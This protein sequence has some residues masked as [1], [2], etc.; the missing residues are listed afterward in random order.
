MKG[1]EAVAWALKNSADTIYTVP[2]YPV[3]EIGDLLRVETVVNEKTAL[4]YALGDSLSGRRSAV[5]VKNVG[6][7]ALADPLINATTQGLISGVVVVAGDDP[8]A[9]FSQNAQ[10]SRYYGELAMAPVV[11]PD[12]KTIF[13]GFSAAFEASE[14][15]SRIAIVRLTPSLLKSEVAFEDTVQVLRNGRLADTDLTIAGRVTRAEKGTAGLFAW[16]KQS[17]LNQ[18]RGGDIGVGM[19]KGDSQVIIPYP[20]PQLPPGSRIIEIGR[21]FLR[22]HH[23]LLPPAVGR[24]SE[25]FSDRGFYR[26]CCPDCPYTPLLSLLKAKKMKVIPDIGCALLSMN[27]PYSI[28]VASYCLGSSVAVAARS[29]CIA[30][31]GDGALLHSGLTSLIDCHAKG[32]PLLVIVLA[33]QRMAMTGGQPVSDICQYLEWAEPLVIPAEDTKTLEDV[34]SVPEEGQKVLIIQGRCPEDAAYEKVEC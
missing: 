16:T 15:F 20:P 10:D 21:P 6:M 14:R 13:T 31:I 32:Y 26:T 2:G 19:A 17:P 28:G 5:L 8:E 9:L 33:N 34:L 4:E 12:E 22:E 25:R 7:N 3:T 30:L 27:P 11:E 18:L 24:S 29:T 23:Q 1:F